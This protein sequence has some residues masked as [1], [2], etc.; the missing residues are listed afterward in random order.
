MKTEMMNRMVALNDTE[1]AKV[2]GGYKQTRLESYGTTG[3]HAQK[4]TTDNKS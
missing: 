1:M 2:I 4:K 3:Y